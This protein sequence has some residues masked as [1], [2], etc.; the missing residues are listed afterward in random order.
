MS[1]IAPPPGSIIAANEFGRYCI[2]RSSAHRPSAALVREGYV[3][4]RDTIAYLRAHC[5]QGDV[6][7][8]GAY[9]G[10]FLPAIARALAPGALVWA[11]E[12]NPENFACA[13]HTVELNGLANVRLHLGGLAQSG[14][15]LT[16]QTMEAGRRS[17]G[18]ASRVVSP[19]ARRRGVV[20]VP[21]FALDDIVAGRPIAIIQLDVEGYEQEALDGA[22]ATIA[23]TR[24]IIM[25]ETEP[26][27]SWFGAHLKPLGYRA[28]GEADVNTIYRCD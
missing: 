27:A 26:A 23:R 11:F 9:F 19:L 25:V 12:P 13:R 10:D 17:L 2:P 16:I 7:H 6:V 8:A 15:T 22:R 20:E 28:A 1:D 3:W 18:G 4:E 21:G 14:R 24:P 5:G